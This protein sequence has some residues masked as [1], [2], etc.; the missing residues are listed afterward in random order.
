MW[1]EWQ[2]VPNHVFG[3]ERLAREWIA[4]CA[5]Q[6]MSLGRQVGKLTRPR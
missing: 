4:G 2:D 5:E 3:E 1:R 6:L